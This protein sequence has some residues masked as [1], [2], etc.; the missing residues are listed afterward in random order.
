[1][2]EDKKF[3]SYSLTDEEFEKIIKKYI[4]LIK[5]KSKKAGIFKDDCMQEIIIS[6]HHSLTRKRDKNNKF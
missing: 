5:D 3:N 1:M 4:P 2:G 6:F